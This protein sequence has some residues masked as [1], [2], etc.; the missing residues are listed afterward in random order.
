M[1]QLPRNAE[2]EDHRSCGPW[3]MALL[4]PRAVATDTEG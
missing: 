3:A 4:V 1:I 2:L